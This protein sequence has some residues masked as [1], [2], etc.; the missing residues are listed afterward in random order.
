MS[1]SSKDRLTHMMEELDSINVDVAQKLSEVSMV[2]EQLGEDVGHAVRSLQFEDMSRQ[3]LDHMAHRVEGLNQ[4]IG[5]LN[6]FDRD[7]A[8]M[9]A[10]PDYLQSEQY[11]ERIN[12]L[13]IEVS[14]LMEDMRETP[15]TQQDM[16]E[17][18]VELF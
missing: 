12:K 3:L 1:L 6:Q 11:F 13:R 18:E 2:S 10:S 17:G 14:L 8:N 5:C 9:L 7:V 16:G 4:V 15:V